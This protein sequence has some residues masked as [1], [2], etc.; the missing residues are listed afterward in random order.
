MISDDRMTVGSM[1]SYVS[2]T[3]KN[4]LGD[5]V[6]DFSTEF[7]NGTSLITRTAGSPR[8]F[9]MGPSMIM[10][11]LQEGGIAEAWDYHRERV[12]EYLAANPSVQA[13]ACDDGNAYLETVAKGYDTFKKTLPQKGCLINYDDLCFIAGDLPQDFIDRAWPI[14][15]EE[16]KRRGYW[17]EK[18]ELPESSDGEVPFAFED[19]GAG[20]FVP[21]GELDV[22]R[23]HIAIGRSAKSSFVKSLPTLIITLIIFFQLGWFKWGMDFVLW[24]IAI[25]FLHEGGHYIVMKIFGYKNLRMMFLPLMGAAVTGVSFG[26]STWKKALVSLAGPLPGIFLGIALLIYSKKT[27]NEMVEKPVFLLMFLNGFNLL[28]LLP[29][30]GG[31]VMQYTLFSRWYVFEYIARV[32]ACMVFLTLAATTG[33][34]IFYILGIFNVFGMVGFHKESGFLKSFKNEFSGDQIAVELAEHG[35][36]YYIPDIYLQRMVDF[37]RDKK[38]ISNYTVLAGEVVNLWDRVSVKPTG[39]WATLGVWLVYLSGWMSMLVCLALIY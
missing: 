25:L 19:D 37:L 13:V 2:H 26:V 36:D 10:R 9:D 28:P 29:L 12:R 33:D 24:L 1:V 17:F 22:I 27:G 34:Y 14:C 32:L 21:H 11:N 6:L 23:N 3:E 38:K 8:S 4:C 5:T 35:E 39:F 30:D 7:T 18:M 15:I 31:W 16:Q 20:D